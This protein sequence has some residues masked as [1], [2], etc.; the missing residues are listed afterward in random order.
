MAG[1]LI[2]TAGILILTILCSVTG[3]IS[4]QYNAFSI[5]LI[6]VILSVFIQCTAEEL[7]RGYVPAVLEGSRKWDTIASVSG[8]LFIFHHSFNDLRGDFIPCSV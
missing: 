4:L 5:W 2:G 6:P 8:T 7:L 3:T 1:C